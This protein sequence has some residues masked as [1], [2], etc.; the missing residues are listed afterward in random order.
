MGR[1]LSIISAFISLILLTACHQDVQFSK[2]DFHCY[3]FVDGRA[4]YELKIDFDKRILKAKYYENRYPEQKK[5]W[6]KTLIL[7][8]E[9]FKKWQRILNKSEVDRWDNYYDSN[10]ICGL[11][12]RLKYILSTGETRTLGGHNNWPDEISIIS[13]AIQK[14]VGKEK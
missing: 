10:L 7:D 4:I 13:E 12:W 5:E 2:I 1:F 6:S 14:E 8:S 9:Q 11:I 3:S